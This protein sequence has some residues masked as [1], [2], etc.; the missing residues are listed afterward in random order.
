MKLTASDRKALVRLAGTLPKGSEERRAILAGLKK[1]GQSPL[2]K[3]NYVYVE[4]ESVTAIRYWRGHW[5]VILQGE[6]ISY[7]DESKF[8]REL[9]NLFQ[10]PKREADRA[11]DELKLY[12][13]A[14]YEQS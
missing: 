14:K 12:I 8:R 10:V 7:T 6:A 5:G 2:L 1:A 11:V 4:S 9:V 3:G 13:A